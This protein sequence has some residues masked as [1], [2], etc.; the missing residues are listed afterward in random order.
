MRMASSSGSELRHGI[1]VAT[2]CLCAEQKER[3]QST[4]ETQQ[5]NRM[6]TCICR[7][8]DSFLSP[9]DVVPPAAPASSP[10]LATPPSARSSPALLVHRHAS[11]FDVVVPVC[12]VCTAKPIPTPLATVPLRVLLTHLHGRLATRLSDA[13]GQDCYG[14]LVNV[15]AVHFLAGDAFDP[16]EQL[17]IVLR[18]KGDRLAGSSS[19]RR[20]TNAMNVVFGMRWNVVIDDNVDEWNVETAERRKVGGASVRLSNGTPALGRTH[21]LATS[22]ATNT[23]RPPLLNLFSA[24]K[25]EL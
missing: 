25:R 13:F 5:A 20:S 8:K 18:D 15:V 10:P 12:I 9:N 14:L 6:T 16:L 21:R 23:L 19:T 3:R 1:L 11:L 17:D 4:Q 7:G 24:P 2:L 22:V